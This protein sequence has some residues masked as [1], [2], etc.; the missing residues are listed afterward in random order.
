MFFLKELKYFIEN[1]DELVRL[2]EGKVIAIK[3]QEVVGVFDSKVD[4]FEKIL[5]KYGFGQVMIKLCEPG[6]MA[7]TRHM[8]DNFRG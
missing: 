5:G 2:Y 4:A 1:Q 3:S 6:I 7:H 8:P